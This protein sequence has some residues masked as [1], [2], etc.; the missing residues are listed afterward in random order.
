MKKALFITS[1]SLL[2]LVLITSSCSGSKTENK[3]QKV[4]DQYQCPMKCTEEVFD[5]PGKC[6]VCEMDLEKINNS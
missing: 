5:K 4:A 2:S 1:F 6:T 3:E